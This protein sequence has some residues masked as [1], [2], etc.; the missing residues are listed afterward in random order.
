MTGLI[1]DVGGTNARFALVDAEGRIGPATVLAN[2]D[3]PSLEAAIQA[4]LAMLPAGSKP[5]RAAIAVACP[6]GGDRIG[7]TNR[8]W[9][10]SIAGLKESLGFSRLDVVNDFA[11]VALSL[12]YLTEADLHPVGGGTAIAGAPMIAIGPGT[13]LGV[14][15]LVPTPGGGWIP[16]ATEGGHATL[17]AGTDREAAVLAIL[18]R[19][20]GH[21]S[22]ERVLSGPGLANLRRALG[23]LEGRACDEEFDPIG[24]T[25][26]ALD[27]SCKLCWDAVDI[28]CALLGEV[29]G[30]AALT[31]GA[32]GG[33][34]IA[35]GIVPKL[36]EAFVRSPFRTRFEAKGRMAPYV[37][38]IPTA[39]VVNDQ[40]A[41]LGLAGLVVDR[42]GG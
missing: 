5:D 35:G 11:A 4:F 31:V 32:R 37:Q 9:S 16:L 23:R 10:F 34:F 1:A 7:L 18:R 2:D 38:A 29:A 8:D 42:S 27:G 24:V 30:N 41:F 19:E 40:P 39:V 33:V 6:V 17:P 3:Y 21:V 20:F 15:V 14:S 22:A 36:G 13:G 28:F 12:P 26:R 25:A